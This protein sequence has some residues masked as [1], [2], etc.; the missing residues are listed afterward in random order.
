MELED[1]TTPEKGPGWASKVWGRMSTLVVN[2]ILGA[3]CVGIV[4]VVMIVVNNM[5]GGAHGGC[6]NC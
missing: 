6:Y 2:L 5:P 1:F 4:V 3:L